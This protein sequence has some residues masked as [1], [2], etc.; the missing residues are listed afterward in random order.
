M[1]LR[2]IPLGQTAGQQVVTEMISHIE[3][4]RNHILELAE[5]IL[6]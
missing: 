1:Q 5:V 3:K 6:V 2:A 4:V